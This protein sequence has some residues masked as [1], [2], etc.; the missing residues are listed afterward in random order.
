MCMVALPRSHARCARNCAIAD[1][2]ERLRT[3]SSYMDRVNQN[4]SL[5]KLSQ[6][7]LRNFSFFIT[8]LFLS[9]AVL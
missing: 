7:R 8:T 5:Q 2:T 1:W 9:L 6:P 4:L 3:D